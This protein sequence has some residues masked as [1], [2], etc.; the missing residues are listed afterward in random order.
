MMRQT[1]ALASRRLR[2]A[3]ELVME[4]RR[5]VEARETGIHWVE[6]GN[7]ECRLARRE[8]ARVCGE[9]VGGFEEVCASWRER[10]AGGTAGV[11]V[12]VA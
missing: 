1:T 3:K 12:G 4:M 2:A 8:C 10:L 6:Q 7:W 11:E 5:E 9:V